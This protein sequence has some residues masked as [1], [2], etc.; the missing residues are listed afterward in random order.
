[1]AKG[2]GWIAASRIVITTIGFANTLILARLL[3]PEDFGLVAIV[4]AASAI[5]FAATDLSLAQALVQHPDPDERHYH[6][7]FTLNLLRG[8]GIAVLVAAISV[9]A[10]LFYDDPRLAPLF[11]TIAVWALLSGAMNPKL[12]MM[13][14]DLVFWQ[15][16]AT[17]SGDKLAS[18]LV[19]VTIAAIWQSYWALIIGLLA[20]QVFA[21]IL[22]Y[23]IRP[24][25][26]RLSLS[27]WRDL[28]SFSIWVGLGQLVNTINWR[29]DQLLAGYVLGTAQLGYYSVGDRL[30]AT[31]TREA[32]Q[33]LAQTVF[34]GFA[35][36]ARDLP[37]LR[38]AYLRAQ[39][40]LT[41]VAL[42]AGAG[43]AVTAEPL[44]LLVLGEDWRPIVPVIQILAAVFAVQ[45]LATPAQPLAMALGATRALF[46]RSLVMLAIRVPLTII[47]LFGWGLLGLLWARCVSGLIGTLVNMYLVQVLI[48]M[49]ATRQVTGNWR[50]IIAT[51]AMATATHVVGLGFEGH[52]ATD[53][54]AKTGAMVGTGLLIYPAAHFSLWW[55][56]GRPHGPERDAITFGGKALSII[57]TRMTTRT[58]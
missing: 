45:T 38:S 33:P 30:A 31:P 41:A 24:F 40:L 20:G 56:C 2:A 8:V 43:F 50:A 15:D 53:L 51:A 23:A 48:A 9:P 52:T 28:M 6:T 25:W 19:A 10:S 13:S 22:S 39:A 57:R 47:G 29:F 46:N 21:L 36:L 1:M 35:K 32:T 4:M 58:A 26:P 16:F 18:V 12:A 42:P 7:A 44:T 54:L 5:L 27:R 14:R 37:R 34:P 11:A 17:R 55:L 49:P 3:T